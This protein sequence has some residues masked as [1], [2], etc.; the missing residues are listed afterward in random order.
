MGEMESGRASKRERTRD[1]SQTIEWGGNY[2]FGRLVRESGVQ[3][4]ERLMDVMF[5]WT[6]G[7]GGGQGRKER[8]RRARAEKRA[9]VS[10]CD[11]EFVMVVKAA[12]GLDGGVA[13]GAR[14]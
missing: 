14:W 2:P 13:D 10:C 11:G 4:A 5:V 1:W 9:V 6:T 7:T 12:T 8:G 3:G